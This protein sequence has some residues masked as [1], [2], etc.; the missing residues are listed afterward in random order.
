MKTHEAIKDIPKCQRYI[1][2]PSLKELLR[3]SLL[4]EKYMR[5]NLIR[6]A[7]EM[8]GYSQNEVANHLDLH[9]STISRLMK[10]D[11][12]T[13]KNKTPGQFWILG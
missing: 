10:E 12:N 6:K 1:N 4:R 3:E 11:V 7:V 8:H 5:D 9:Y 2:R 13:S